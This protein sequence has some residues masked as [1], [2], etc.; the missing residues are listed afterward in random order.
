MKQSYID[1][2][3]KMVEE[4]VN[5]QPFDKAHE[6]AYVWNKIIKPHLLDIA[7]G[8]ETNEDAEQWKHIAK[9][10]YRDKEQLQTQLTKETKMREA[11][12]LVISK[13]FTSNGTDWQNAL[14]AWQQSKSEEPGSYY[15]NDKPK[16]EEGE[17]ESVSKKVAIKELASLIQANTSSSLGAAKKAAYYCYF[18]FKNTTFSQFQSTNNK[19]V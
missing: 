5:K 13:S 15:M 18:Y 8:Q 3:E 6:I 14:N 2:L 19:K 10:Y 11:A 9:G 16:A 1:Q 12:E 4:Y 17:D 7:E